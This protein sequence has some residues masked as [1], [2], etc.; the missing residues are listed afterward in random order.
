MHQNPNTHPSNHR[1]DDQNTSATPIQSRETNQ[2]RNAKKKK[3]VAAIRL[4]WRRPIRR[5]NSP[6][7]RRKT[8]PATEPSPAYPPPPKLSPPLPSPAPPS[9]ADTTLPR[10]DRRWVRPKEANFRRNWVSGEDRRSRIWEWERRLWK[11][12]PIWVGGDVRVRGSTIFTS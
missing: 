9:A 7:A 1:S 11:S 10:H 8:S 3:K 6:A 12:R 2:T 4:T 5:R